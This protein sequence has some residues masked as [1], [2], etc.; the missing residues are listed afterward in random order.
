MRRWMIGR[1]S[2]VSS[3]LFGGLV[4]T[5]LLWWGLDVRFTAEIE[6]L[7]HK[8][9]EVELEDESRQDRMR[10]DQSLRAHFTFARL[11]GGTRSVARHVE[12]IAGRPAGPP[13]VLVNEPDWLPPRVDR[14]AF[15]LINFLIVIG[16]DGTIRE[17]VSLTGDAVPGGLY[18]L[19]GRLIESASHQAYVTR[20][21]AM[22]MVLSVAASGEKGDKV[23]LLSR[24]DSRFLAFNS[25]SSVR[26][27]HVIAISEGRERV[28]VASSDPGLVAPGAS[29]AAL[30][31]E[32]LVLGMEFFDYG[33]SEVVAN[34]STLVSR[35]LV[36]HR[37]QPLLVQERT[38]RTVLAGAMS[39]MLLVILAGLVF[40]LRATIRRVDQVTRQVFGIAVDEYRGG[41]ELAELLNK[42]EVLTGEVMSSRDRL[43]AEEAERLQLATARMAIEAENDRLRLLQTVTDLLGVGVIRTTPDGAV[44]ENA[45]MVGYEAACGGLQP[46]LDAIARDSSDL[47]V[48][49]GNGERRV[50]ELRRASG[51]SFE[52]LLVTDVT[53]R[54]QI[55][56]EVRTLALF[57]AQSPYPVLRVN[58]DG[59]IS[60]ANPAST[61]LLEEWRTS[62]G[63]R[64]P[65]LW[66]R[67]IGDVLRGAHRAI[68]ECDIGGR[69]LALTL[70]PIIN[71]GYVNVY[72][73]DVSA[74]VEVERMLA[75]ANEGL[76]RRVAQRTADL[77]SA[78]EQAEMASRAKT[79]F[80]ATVS[81]ELR[82][83]L[84]AIIGFSEV[85][86]S[87]L[88]GPLGSARYEGY[89]GD[90]LDSARH[91]LEVIN[92]I[93]DVAK[94][95]SGEM[96]LH[97]EE[98]DLT[99]LM[100]AAVRLVEGRARNGSVCLLTSIGGNVPLVWADRRRILQ[101]LVNL[102]SNAVKFTQAGGTVSTAIE[103]T[104]NGVAM[105]VTD[106][107]IGMDADEVAVA[108]Q[109]FRQVDGSLARRFEGTGLGLPLA[110]SLTELH[111]GE[112]KLVSARGVGT[113]VT[114]ALP[115][116]AVGQE[117][118]ATA[119]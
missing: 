83:P 40:R 54:R 84:N 95:E 50:F 23:A 37:I 72:S 17:V 74:R 25:I 51:P 3:F 73:A 24:L 31:A 4:A 52:M 7:T 46:F 32:W 71:G 26:P 47:V 107:G 11:L 36:E 97:F 90:I 2:L 86:A 118:L 14:R 64:V 39:S 88:F 81:H 48:V 19:D 53:A 111:G 55:E 12:A 41:D 106:T 108:L 49:D 80:L 105:K 66:R 44:A 89:A 113:E 28:V 114:V 103:A 35:R 100:A 21:G 8:A 59:T 104:A 79:E 109:P 5:A 82:T 67:R 85:M 98:V 27:D 1:S 112:L 10:F 18:A 56:D 33:S 117:T 76:E 20:I 6:A 30:A 119:V 115:L 102:L 92:D 75:S 16:K 91:L 9:L 77:L 78:K 94:I 65:N 69:T 110:K 58:Q 93:L 99:E 87:A 96:A 45:A 15:P 13:S 57:T 101:I 62:V 29:L 43:R 116:T 34:F 22:P 63:Q 38:Q 70:V 68:I 42:V 61:T 60:H